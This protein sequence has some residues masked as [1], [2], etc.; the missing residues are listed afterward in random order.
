MTQPQCITPQTHHVG[1][2]ASRSTCLH[3]DPWVS[4]RG[5]HH[6]GCQRQWGTPVQ[7]VGCVP[8]AGMLGYSASQSRIH[9]TCFTRLVSPSQT[10]RS[11]QADLQRADESQNILRRCQGAGNLSGASVRDPPS[12]CGPVML[13]ALTLSYTG[14]DA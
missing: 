10:Y 6:R 2:G 8:L 14:W 7:P 5:A 9:V 11:C 3:C 12:R 4:A 1:R 13:D